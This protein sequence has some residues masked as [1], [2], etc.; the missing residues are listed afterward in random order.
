M[1]VVGWGI[2]R[3]AGDYDDVAGLLVNDSAE[4]GGVV[5]LAGEVV[6]GEDG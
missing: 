5:A 6:G 4:V 1:V 2:G 3:F